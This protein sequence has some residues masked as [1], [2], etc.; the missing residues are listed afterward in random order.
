MLVLARRRGEKIVITVPLIANHLEP[1]AS[2]DITVMV[3][4]IQGKQV[5][6]GVQAPKDVK[7]LRSEKIVDSI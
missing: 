6:I 3:T 7:V 5:R 4:Q 1:N 2:V